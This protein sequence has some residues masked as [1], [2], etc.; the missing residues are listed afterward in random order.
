[1]G[2][3]HR[4]QLLQESMLRS[5]LSTADWPA[6]WFTMAISLWFSSHCGLYIL[7]IRTFLQMRIANLHVFQILFDLICYQITCTTADGN[8][9][10]NKWLGIHYLPNS[11]WLGHYKLYNIIHY[12]AHAHRQWQHIPFSSSVE[13]I[14]CSRL[15]S[16]WA[17]DRSLFPAYN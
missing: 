12:Y 2:S 6:E 3:G 11:K 9:K 1:M 13:V 14:I 17:A 5:T 8:R 10:W 16:N 4:L 7:T 15:P